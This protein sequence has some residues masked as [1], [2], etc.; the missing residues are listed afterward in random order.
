MS[1]IEG[2]NTLYLIGNGFDL[3]HDIKSS[4]SNFKDWLEIN[5]YVL[6]N[7]L[8]QTYD[9]LGCDL[10]GNLEV[11]LAHITPEAILDSN[12]AAPFLLQI[13]N[14]YSAGCNGL[15]VDLGNIASEIYSLK[16]LYLNLQIEFENWIESLSSGA[17]NKKVRID[18]TNSF[19]INFNY[20]E[21]LERDYGIPINQIL[22]IHGNAA[23]NEALIFGHNKT[24]PQLLNQWHW[25][26]YNEN[27]KDNLQYAAEEMQYFY[28]DV[29]AIINQNSK[30]WSKFPT[31]KFI[32]IWGLSL[33]EVDLPYIRH[34]KSV[35]PIDAKWEFTWHTDQ[36]KRKVDE[37]AQ[38]LGIL[39]YSLVRLDDIIQPFPEQLSLFPDL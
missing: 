12:F 38:S 35:L 19:F 14:P 25:E 39:D 15:S 30:L 21:T 7:R 31:V 29:T 34:I 23:S 16:D 3:H 1:S 6:F 33:S 37:V 9:L 24:I 26:H 27:D 10:W 8:F 11:N 20:T 36:D 22:H 28:K 13:L 4:Y 18:K 32:H 17:P 2:I 5:N